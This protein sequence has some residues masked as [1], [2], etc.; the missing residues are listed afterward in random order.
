MILAI[1]TEPNGGKHTA[2]FAASAR[3]E[4][5]HEATLKVIKGLAHT[6]FRVINDDKFFEEVQLD[7]RRFNDV[8]LIQY[9]YKVHS[10][11]IK[12]R[13]KSLYNIDNSSCRCFAK[14]SC[15]VL[16]KEICQRKSHMSHYMSQ[17]E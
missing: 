9:R 3:T 8:R 17:K 10:R 7:S 15:K 6:G 4:E 14:I 13:T 1:P 5:A 2:L 12:N 16:P 11:V